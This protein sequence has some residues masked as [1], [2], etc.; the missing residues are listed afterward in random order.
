MAGRRF[1]DQGIERKRQLVDVAA[2]LFAERG[3]A[4]TRIVDICE[5]AGV[6]KGLFYWY[7]ENKEVLFA[8]L[9]HTMRL[10]LRK[11]QAEAMDMTADPLVRLRQGA[12]ASVMFIAGHSA[13]FAL[14]DVENRER[15]FTE[16]LREGTLVHGAD[17]QVLVREGIESGLIRDDDP[18]VLA[19]GI[20]GAVTT[21]SH[22]HR[23]GRITMTTP[24]LA[25]AVGRWVVRAL[26]ADEEI[27]RTAER[28]VTG[29]AA[30]G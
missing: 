26:A 4:D 10:R 2:T 6:A 29:L 8:E 17:V 23:T 20:V 3:Y 5:Q 24:E 9:V 21:Y 27:A 18:T 1:T 16:L 7:F 19:Y 28:P 25:A 11:A 14:L 12:E 22:F 15:R 30:L 13:Y